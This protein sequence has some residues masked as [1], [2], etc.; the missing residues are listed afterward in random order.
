V[1]H[2]PISAAADDKVQQGA[3]GE[4]AQD[5]GGGPVLGYGGGERLTNGD[6]CWAKLDTSERV[7]GLGG[8][9]EAR[10]GAP[11]RRHSGGDV[12]G[13]AGRLEEAST[14]EVTATKEEARQLS[15]STR[16]H[17][18]QRLATKA[19]AKNTAGGAPGAWCGGLPVMA[20]S[21][22]SGCRAQGAERTQRRDEEEVECRRHSL[23]AFV[24]ESCIEVG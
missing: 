9:L 8:R 10:G 24:D 17:A 19:N 20:S 7:G 5:E 3:V 15:S 1:A 16:L 23:C 18:N 2:R 4:L 11:R 13:A 21:A 12:V 6:L 22:A 14:G